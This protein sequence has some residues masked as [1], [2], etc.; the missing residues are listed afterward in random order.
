M[1]EAPVNEDNFP[2][3]FEDKIWL[4]GKRTIMQPE[5]K[6]HA[7]NEASHEEFWLRVS[8]LDERHPYASLLRRERVVSLSHCGLLDLR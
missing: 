6:P 5:S 4:S 8:A 1:P 3:A 2:S 7:V